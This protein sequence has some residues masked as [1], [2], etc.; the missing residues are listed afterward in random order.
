MKGNDEIE[1]KIINVKLGIYAIYHLSFL[2]NYQFE[3]RL[4]TML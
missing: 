3:I 1:C 4:S 2:M